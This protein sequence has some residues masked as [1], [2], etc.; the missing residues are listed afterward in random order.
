MEREIKNVSF[1]MKVLRSCWYLTFIIPKLF[2]LK[3]FG[4]KYGK[5]CLILNSLTDF[6]IKYLKLL[7]IGNDVIISRGVKIF[8]HDGS[9]DVLERFGIKKQQFKKVTIGDGAFIGAS[10]IILPG[11]K[12]GSNSIIGAGSVVTKDV[13]ENSI[14]A[15][16]PAKLIKNFK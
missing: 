7:Y 5:R 11:I 15:G 13:P 12:I 2:L 16:N 10:S 1:F 3:I 6:D 14:V 9:A 4:L 8:T